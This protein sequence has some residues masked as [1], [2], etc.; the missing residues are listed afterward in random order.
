[1]PTDVIDLVGT[2]K[3]VSMQFEFEDNKERV[4]MYGR[5]P[6]GY[7][8]LTEDGRVIVLVTASGRTTPKDDAESA[9]LLNS[10]MSYSGKYHVDGDRF[11]T[12]IDV[13]WHPGWVNTDQVR[14]FRLEGQRLSILTDTQTHPLFGTRRGKGVITWSRA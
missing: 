9:S 10:M 13:A 4:D 2:W 12:R 5:A 14:L 11:V 3:L 6:L 7:M 1:M 8:I